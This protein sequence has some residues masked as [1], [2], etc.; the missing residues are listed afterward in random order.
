MA[1]LYLGTK[2][3]SPVIKET[4]YLPKEKCGLTID[5]FVGDV[6]E[7]GT[8]SSPEKALGAEYIFN[9]VKTIAAGALN[10]TFRNNENV[11][12]ISFPDLE[13][14]SGNKACFELAM[15]ASNLE[16]FEAPK[17]EVIDGDF[18]YALNSARQLKEIKFPSLRHITKNGSMTYFCYACYGVELIDLSS[19]EI[20]EGNLHEWIYNLSNV[21][22][23]RLDSLRIYNPST[24]NYVFENLSKI[25][26]I[27]FPSLEEFLVQGQ[28][29]V[30]GSF[31]L[32]EEINF[33]KLTVFHVNGFSSSMFSSSVASRV[34]DIHFRAD[35]R[36]QVENMPAYSNKFGA[37]NANI[38]FDL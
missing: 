19:L 11:K 38:Y 18:G 34:F 28:S 33:P 12:K 27:D 20:I 35:V 3:S 10:G 17:L 29:F 26:K 9:G 22:E 16:S 21:S 4:I 30:Y 23:I 6:D 15:N 37:T 7:E 31:P 2:E 1:K 32:L 24:S 25:K 5:N 8:L 13:T 36:E 14:I